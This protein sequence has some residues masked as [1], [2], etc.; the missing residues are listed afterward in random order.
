MSAMPAFPSQYQI[1]D[2]GDI[3]IKRNR[4]LTVR[5]MRPWG[6]DGLFLGQAEDTD[7]E[8]TPYQGPK[9]N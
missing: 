2:Q 1:T 8:K 6:K 4:V 9:N 3:I 7:I 5:A